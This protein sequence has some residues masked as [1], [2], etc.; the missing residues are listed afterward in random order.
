MKK[1]YFYLIFFSFF[2]LTNIYSETILLKNGNVIKA[3][4]IE[5]TSKEITIKTPDGKVQKFS[6]FSILKV[7]YKDIDSIEAQ[8]IKLEEEKKLAEKNK[9]AEEKKLAEEALKKPK[10]TTETKPTEKGKTRMGVVWRSMLIPGWGQHEENRKIPSIIYPSVIALSLFGAY[11]KNREY[12]NSVR[13]F[14]NLGSPYFVPPPSSATLLNPISAYIYNKS[15]ENQRDAVENHKN[16][17]NTYLMGA[18]LVYLINIADAAYFYK[19]E[20]SGRGII[21]DY[22]PVSRKNFP[23][24]KFFEAEYNFGYFIHF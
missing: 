14:N 2:F 6:K 24:G 21:F 20:V 3:K 13:D 10:K 11:E 9:A 17:R 19:D 12:R 4:V 22:S 8:K 16:T 18:L 7:I 5:Q 23:D 15:F 1:I